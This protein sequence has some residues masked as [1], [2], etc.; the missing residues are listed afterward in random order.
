MNDIEKLQNLIEKGHQ[1]LSTHRP[2]PPGVIGFST[3]DS[4]AF[5]A[6]Q[7]QCLSFLES[8]LSPNS[9]YVRTFSEKIKKGY[10]GTVK[11]SIGILQSVM[12][13]LSSEDVTN[14]QEKE[15]NPIDPIK[16]ICDRFHLIARQLRSRH[17]DRETLDIRDEYDVQDLFHSLLH[18]Y[19]E[20][21]RPEEYTPSYAGKASRM[22][23]LPKQEQIVVEIKKARK[24]LG[25][26][27]LGSQLIEDI[28]RYKVHPDCDGL[29]CF[30]YDPEGRIANPRG[31]EGDLSRTENGFSVEVLIRP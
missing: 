9:P 15:Y 1:V 21:I 18:L 10:Q 5:T 6:W 12:E 22:D 16:N 20:D 7:T 23:F 14:I 28:A 4:Q 17:E 13:D 25:A 8:R 26:K 19:F 11:S 3:L 29:I 2:N 24:G 30:T 27:E 31:I